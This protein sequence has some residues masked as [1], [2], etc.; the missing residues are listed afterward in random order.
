MTLDPPSR[1]ELYPNM[2]VTHINPEV[3]E[4]KKKLALK[5]NEITLILK[6]GVKER[7]IALSHG[8]SKWSDNRLNATILNINKETEK[9][10]L[11]NLILDTNRK[12]APRTTTKIAQLCQK[13]DMY[14]DFETSSMY[15]FASDYLFMIG[16]AVERNA[17]FCGLVVSEITL[18]DEL[19]IFNEFVQAIKALNICRIIHWG[20]HEKCV[21]KKIAQRHDI[22]GV[23]DHIVWV[24]LCKTIQQLPFI[25]KGAFNFKLKSVAKAMHSYGMINT[26]WSSQCQDGQNAMFDAFI[27]FKVEDNDTLKDILEYNRVDVVSM[28][29]IYRYLSSMFD[30][31]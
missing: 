6:L 7:E 5:N 17:T 20:D 8:I 1:K 9:Y 3:E 31:L 2:C 14:V 26:V 25:P 30:K 13:G 23:P 11:V 28:M 29:E 10:A 21:C 12:E 24:D 27:A 19:K 22:S 15:E 4:F 18:A 16:Y